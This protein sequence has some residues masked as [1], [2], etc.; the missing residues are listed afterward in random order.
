MTTLHGCGHVGVSWYMAC[1]PHTQL[2]PQGFVFAGRWCC[3]HQPATVHSSRDHGSRDGAATQANLEF[4][5]GFAL[6]TA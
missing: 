2:T 4:G 1:L 3:H 5:Q 6:N